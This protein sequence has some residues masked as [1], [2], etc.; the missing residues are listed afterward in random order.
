VISPWFGLPAALAAAFLLVLAGVDMS[1]AEPPRRSTVGGM[2]FRA[3]V[4]LHHMLQPLVR[5]W[6][7]RRHRHF[8]RRQLG[9]SES[10]PA[11]VQRVR[12]GIVVVPED[13]PRPEL[14]AT[15][16]EAMRRR[17]IRVMYPTGW[18]DCDARLLLSTLVL[19]ELQ[20]S[21]HPEG[22][23]QVRIRTRPRW[24]PLAGAVTVGAAAVM[25]GPAIA[26][27]LFLLLPTASLARGALRARRLPGQIL[28]AGDGQ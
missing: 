14:A 20:T 15:L 25:V 21:S 10:L 5:W 6:A 12:G 16:L 18:E 23:V 17:G 3:L 22:F 28:D 13:R 19:G 24:Q 8:A 7:R 26:L 11:A 27:S 1:R 2:R 4:A 9:S